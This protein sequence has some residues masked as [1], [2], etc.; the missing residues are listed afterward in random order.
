MR[1]GGLKSGAAAADSIEAQ[2]AEAEQEQGARNR[3]GLDFAPKCVVGAIG[4]TDQDV[5]SV[6]QAH[7]HAGH[8]SSQVATS[9]VRRAGDR[10]VADLGA[11][12][13]QH[14]RLNGEAARRCVGIAN[15]GV[16]GHI[17]AELDSDRPCHSWH[18][19]PTSGAT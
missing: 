12:G 4:R 18:C 11:A 1:P 6:E 15:A 8:N 13:G 16:R 9:A 10:N 7:I 19:R 17:L 5:E 3:N 2:E 14:C